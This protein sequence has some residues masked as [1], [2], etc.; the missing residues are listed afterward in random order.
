MNAKIANQILIRF[1]SR[2]FAAS[3]YFT[4]FGCSPLLHGS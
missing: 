2:K 1:N 4:Y 3:T